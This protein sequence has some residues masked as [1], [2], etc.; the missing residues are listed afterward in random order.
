VLLQLAVRRHQLVDGLLR[1]GG[2]IEDSLDPRVDL[3]ER[4][5]PLLNTLDAFGELVEAIA[6]RSRSLLDVLQRLPHLLQLRRAHRNLR[7]HRAES[8]ALFLGGGDEALEIVGLPLGLSS[9]GEPLECV[10]HAGSSRP[11]AAAAER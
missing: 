5:R 11:L 1:L 7:Q 10:K 4:A 2:R 3:V 6:G 8:A 9:P